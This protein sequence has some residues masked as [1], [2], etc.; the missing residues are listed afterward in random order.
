MYFADLHVH[1]S[2]S[3][4]SM[5][6]ESILKEAKE[7]GLT[8]LVFTD[9][10]TT[11]LALEHVALAE[12]YG[13]RAVPGVE[14]SAYD[15]RK[16][17]KVHILGYGYEKT[18][19][20]EQIGSETLKKRNENCLKQIGILNSLGYTVPVDEVK[21]LAGRCIYKQHILEYLVRSGQ[22][23]EL[24][25]EIYRNIFKNGGPCDFDIEYP[26]AEDAVRAIKADGGLA[27]LAHPG[28]QGNYSVI[29]RLVEA[30]LDGIEYNHPSHSETDKK[31][32]EE[33]ARSYRLFMTGGSDFHGRY[34]KT[35]SH[36]GQYPAHESSREIFSGNM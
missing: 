8:H 26:D 21:K 33:F 6:A 4:C 13:I 22:S 7:K 20:I 24:F 1:S 5:D 14:M 18:K 23:K 2:V 28:Q 17:R 32:V 27:V 3:D 30:G 25:G 11:E 12:K 15:Y 10:D 16:S 9:H 34:E 36:L 31:K 29:H 19:Y 35:V